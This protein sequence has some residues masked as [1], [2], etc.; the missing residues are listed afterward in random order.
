M[1]AIDYVAAGPGIKSFTST[2]ILII[3][4]RLHGDRNDAG[5]ADFVLRVFVVVVHF[6]A[7]DIRGVFRHHEGLDLVVVDPR[8]HHIAASES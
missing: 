4:L 7:D 1:R 3:S 8:L 6:G 2:A 5:S